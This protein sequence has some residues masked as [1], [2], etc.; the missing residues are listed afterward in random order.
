VQLRVLKK[1]IRTLWIILGLFTGS[2]L[3]GQIDLTGQWA[4]RYHEDQLERIPGPDVGDYLGIPINDDLRLRADSWDASLLTLLEHQC[5]PHPATYS[6]RGPAEIRISNDMDPVTQQ[7]R[8]IVIYGTFGRAT[9][10][11]WMDGRPHPPEWAPHTWAGFS[12]G[13]WEGE[14]LVVKT[15]HI[16]AGYLR[17]NGVI[18]SDLATVEEYFTRHGDILVDLAIRE[19]PVYLTEPFVQSTNWVINTAQQINPQKCIPL[20]EIG[21]RKPGYV[22]HHLPDANPM[23][24]DFSN[25]FFVPYDATRGGAET[26]YPEYRQKVKTMPRPQGLARTRDVTGAAK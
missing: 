19:D 23:L 1:H 4:A 11:V 26:M 17:R 24:Q 2:T 12:T 7:L 21:S 25:R 10:T 18:H 20:E 5:I 3:F 13:H 14:T 22:P 6:M 9:R 16:K 8:A 15:T